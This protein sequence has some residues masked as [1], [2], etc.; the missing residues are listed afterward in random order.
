MSNDSKWLINQSTEEASKFNTGFSG[1]GMPE[2][3]YTATLE[4][5][6]VREWNDK[7]GKPLGYGYW[8][9]FEWKITG[10]RYANRRI[11]QGQ[12]PSPYNDKLTGDELEQEKK[13]K[14]KWFSFLSALGFDNFQVSETDVVKDGDNFYLMSIGGKSLP[15]GKEFTIKVW[16]KKNKE[17]GQDEAQVGWIVTDKNGKTA[18]AATTSQEKPSLFGS[19]RRLG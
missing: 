7:T 18:S 1:N 10:P 15:L 17:S 8:F 11:W 9:S 4:K 19:K 12:W 16:N 13:S 3:D 6:Q 2:G 5:V 14:R